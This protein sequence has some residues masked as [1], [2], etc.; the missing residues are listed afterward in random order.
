MYHTP[1]AAPL[2][3]DTLLLHVPIHRQFRFHHALCPLGCVAQA[4]LTACSP[5]PL[6]PVSKTFPTHALRW[7]SILDPPTHAVQSLEVYKLPD[8]VATKVQEQ[9]E[10]DVARLHGQPLVSSEAEYR[11]FLGELGGAPPPELMGL[12]PAGNE[13]V[14]GVGGGLNW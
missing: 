8:Q 9:Y 12:D 3:Q 6:A 2:A 1:A 7:P 13:G 11:K 14:Q 10:R 4:W 5:S